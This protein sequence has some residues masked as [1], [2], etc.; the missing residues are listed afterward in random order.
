MRSSLLLV[1]S[2]VAACSATSPSRSSDLGLG[3]KFD[4]AGVDQFVDVP[5]IPDGAVAPTNPPP[6]VTS[7][8]GLIGMR[9]YN[10]KVPVGYNK[11]RPT[12]LVIL[13]HGYGATGATQDLYFQ[14]GALADVKTFLYAYPDGTLDPTG[15]HFWNATDAC[16]DFY[17][18]PVNDVAYANA[19]IDDVEKKYNVDAQRIYI[20]GHS[21][22]GFMS[23][24]LA[25]EAPRV[26]AIVSLAGAEWLDAT[27]CKPH[28]P[29]S[30]LEVH[31]DVDTVVLYPGGTFVTG[32]TYPSAR[33]TVADWAKLN[34]CKG[35]LIDDGTR[36]NIDHLIP[37]SET[38]VEHYAGCK[39]GG[40]VQLWTIQGGSHLPV[41][42][43][44]WAP[45]IYGFLEEHPKP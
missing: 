41:L 35:A 3:G 21:N 39:T 38:I 6:P 45:T 43:S 30:V 16:C 23:H 15:Q 40:D 42:G 18:N 4:F 14:L 37:G 13:F 27:K 36:L 22:G 8:G 33:T 1:L 44:N 5:P 9:P 19:I 25:C 2:L 11:T 17:N 10:F 32:G 20:V 24:R 26:A 34:G 28:G 31:G 29:V 7:D 12:P